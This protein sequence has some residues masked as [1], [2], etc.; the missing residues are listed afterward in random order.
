MKH[1]ITPP[2]L[3]KATL[4]TT[5]GI[6]FHPDAEYRKQNQVINRLQRL[7]KEQFGLYIR[8]RDCYTT[9][10]LI[11]NGVYLGWVYISA[12]M[13][14]PVS[15]YEYKYNVKAVQ[16]YFVTIFEW[17]CEKTKIFFNPINSKHDI[18]SH[19]TLNTMLICMQEEDDWED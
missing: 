7:A 13:S 4:G 3:L 11:Y 2:P 1:H 17:E 19:T 9:R 16:N 15:E 8:K 6:L 10:R 14:C 5:T 12:G 18:F